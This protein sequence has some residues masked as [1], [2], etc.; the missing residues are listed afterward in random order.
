[1]KVTPVHSLRLTG[2][3][4]VTMPVV[5]MVWPLVIGPRGEDPHTDP[6]GLGVSRTLA[7][8]IAGLTPVADATE[9]VVVPGV[10]PVATASGSTFGAVVVVVSAGVVVLVVGAAFTTVVVVVTALTFDGTVVVVVVVTAL[11]FAGTVVVVVEVVE[12][13]VVGTAGGAVVGVVLVTVAGVFFEVAVAPVAPRRMATPM[14]TRHVK[15]ALL[16]PKRRLDLVGSLTVHVIG[17]IRGYL[18][19]P[20]A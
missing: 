11:T 20:L 8:A 4:S 6:S 14:A 13:V 12:L 7:L 2:C 3:V 9:V 5:V 16:G 17:T 19:L 1:L 10:D 15:R 18:N